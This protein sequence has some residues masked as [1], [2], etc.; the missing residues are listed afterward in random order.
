MEV[1]YRL[2]YRGIFRLCGGGRIRTSVGEAGRFTVCSL[3]P[4]GHTPG[5]APAALCAERPNMV[6]NATDFSTDEKDCRDLQGEPGKG[7]EPPTGRLQGGCSTSELP[8]RAVA[9]GAPHAGFASLS[10]RPS[11]RLPLVSISA[12]FGPSV[13]ALS[14]SPLRPAR[15]HAA[16]ASGIVT[17]Q[18]PCRH[19]PLLKAEAK[20]ER[21]TFPSGVSLPAYAKSPTK[22][23]LL[24]G[25]CAGRRGCGLWQAARPGG[26]RTRAGWRASSLGR[27]PYAAERSQP[28]RPWLSPSGWRAGVRSRR[29][30]T[31]LGRC[32][33]HEQHRRPA[34]RPSRARDPGA[35]RKRPSGTSPSTPPPLGRRLSGDRGPRRGSPPPCSGRGRR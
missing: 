1:L 35:R 19:R 7:F 23:G 11:L 10:A 28:C 6:A 27:G 33:S 12:R 20:P 34:T 26:S 30:Q 24:Y 17:A 16:H 31:P 14:K 22:V 8:G 4:L 32:R 18:T 25:T 21:A 13:L 2:S 9:G 3:W 5:H 29:P 15:R